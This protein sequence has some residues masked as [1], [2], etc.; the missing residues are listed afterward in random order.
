MKK[1]LFLKN[2]LIITC[3]L[4]LINQS[5]L[6]QTIEDWYVNMPDF[7]NPTLSKQNRL[8]LLEYHKAHQSNSTVN[9][10]GNQAHLLAL[11]SLNNRIL[12]RN[13]PSSTFEM[14]AFKLGNNT[15]A[16]GIIRTICAPVCLSNIE[17]YDTAWNQIPLQFT[18]PKAIEW[19]TKNDIPTDKVDIQWLKNSLGLSFISLSFSTEGQSIVAKNNTL[20]FLSDADRKIIAPYVT[21]K[22][23]SFKLKGRTWIREI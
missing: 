9:R 5:L 2:N 22:P 12:V 7:L 13:T 3:C 8:E 16:I 15:T 10:I 11:D 23:I 21:D 14:K 17:F 6:A 20:E 18:V 4:I 19:I 1:R